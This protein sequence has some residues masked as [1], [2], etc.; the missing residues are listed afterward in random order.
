MFYEILVGEVLATQGNTL[1]GVQN[2]VAAAERAR[3]AAVFKRAMEVAIRGRRGDL[4]RA[5]VQ[6]WQR[7]LPKDP[8]ATRALLHLAVAMQEP[9]AAAEPLARLVN[10][11]PLPERSGVIASVPRFLGNLKDKAAAYAA[12][13][14]AL[15]P[16]ADTTGLATPVAVALARM[17]LAAGQPDDA[18][19]RV[20]RA[21]EADPQAPGP[22]LVALEL[23]ETTPA[24]QPLVDAYLA[25]HDTSAQVRLA[26]ARALAELQQLA[27]AA[28]EAQRA[29][30]AQPDL[31]T[32][33]LT[34]AA[35]RVEL[36]E[37]AAALA[38]LERFRALKAD[39]DA[40]GVA[41]AERFADLLAAQAAL[42]QKDLP[43]AAQW[44]ARLP[45]S[46]SP[47]GTQLLRARLLWLQGQ[48]AQARKLLQ[49]GPANDAPKPVARLR[50]EAQLLREQQ[51]WRPALDVLAQA[52]AL[53]PDDRGLTLEW[54]AAADQLG[55]HQSAEE[56]MRA[57]LAKHP[58]DPQVLNALGYALADRGVRLDEADTLLARAQAA[59]PRDPFITD[60]VGW[61]RFRQGRPA[62]A[63][64][65]L[66]ASFA[67]HPHA[68]VAAHLGEVQWAL[69]RQDE[70]RAVWRDGL[71]RDPDNA[72]LNETIRRVSGRQP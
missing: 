48:E 25:R 45:E 14:Q 17:A 7:T 36:R 58:E 60:S 9:A 16:M 52:R 64:P 35:Y 38:A 59:S 66:K 54:A 41:Q 42:H 71:A 65:L 1:E 44:L 20:R 68:E 57:E 2:L 39:G 31:A 24:A 69:G 5:V 12:A 18:L 51:Q 22:G 70:A 40:E 27:P 56:T 33:W 53:A 46:D 32:A 13:R 26:Y 47:L 15:E 4:A 29:A 63:L 6:S 30:E 55:E 61:L 28:A 3:D 67:A 50:A 72:V 21:A 43:A 37:P 19:A 10:E 62:D 8:E 23:L 34:L 49:S 11:L